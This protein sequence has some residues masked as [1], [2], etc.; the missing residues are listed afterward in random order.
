MKNKELVSIS[1]VCPNCI[2]P[3]I[4]QKKK[5]GSMTNWFICPTCGFRE[6]PAHASITHA[7]TGNFIDAIRF[8][9]SKTANK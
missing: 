2:E 6:R 1:E 7:K 3:L 8:K 9:N 4:L 5:L